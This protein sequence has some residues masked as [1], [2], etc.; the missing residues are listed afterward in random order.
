M[1][2]SLQNEAAKIKEVFGEI[3]NEL[4]AFCN[5]RDFKMANPQL[6]AFLSYCPNALAIASDGTVDVHEMAALL[7][8]SRQI[9]VN[10]MI[11][12]DLLE[13]MSIAPEPEDC[14]LNEEF[15]IRVGAELL[16]L[17]RNME[18]YE[19]NIISAVKHLLK[20]DANPEADKS[21]TKVFAA[22][23]KEIIKNNLSKN[24][25][26]ELKKLKEIQQKLGMPV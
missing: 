17:C 12:M 8:I 6:Y 15:N 11:D 19:S 7:K 10:K 20:F 2:N 18:K 4:D 14:M 1:E 21:L 13:L 5:D 3:R 16:Y 9:D 24:K 25:E 23:M 22:M 26:N